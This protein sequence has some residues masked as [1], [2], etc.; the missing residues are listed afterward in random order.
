MADE[1]VFPKG[2]LMRGKRGLVMGVANDH[3]IAWGIA[4]TAAA[5]GAEVAFTYQG[6]ALGRRVKPLAESVGGKIVLLTKAAD[7][8]EAS[9]VDVPDL[10][11]ERLSELLVGPAG[12]GP[13]G[14]IGAYFVNYLDPTEQE[15]RWPE[16]LAAVNGLGPQLWHLFGAR[17][18][19]AG[20]LDFA[21]T[22]L[23]RLSVRHS[24]S[25]NSTANGS[26]CCTKLLL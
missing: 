9:V 22:L 4:R 18:D 1:W 17:L 21:P 11:P 16:W 12:G 10:T 13:A 15:R 3:S 19:A 6:E 26:R 14:W 25:M 24:A 8:R 5:Q 2:E 7:G 23:T 20:I